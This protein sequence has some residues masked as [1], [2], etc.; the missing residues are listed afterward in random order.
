M[1]V[2]DDDLWLCDDCT[3]YAANGDTSGIEGDKRE[4]EVVK[5]VN[6]LGPNLVPNF[7]SDTGE[8][9]RDFTWRKCDAC[10]SNLGG[11]RTRFALLEE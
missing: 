2:I 9:I 4:R 7:D 3:I 8:G 5:G 10:N 1:K 6:A 11:S